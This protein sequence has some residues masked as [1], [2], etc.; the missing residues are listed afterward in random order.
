M[1][2]ASNSNGKECTKNTSRCGMTTMLLLH[3]TIMAFE[4]RDVAKVPLRPPLAVIR[5]IMM[6]KMR[7]TGISVVDLLVNTEETASML[8]MVQDRVTGGAEA[9]IMKI[10]LVKVGVMNP[11]G[12]GGVVKGEVVGS[13]GAAMKVAPIVKV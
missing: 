6:M 9:M 5:A 1:I 10:I 13:A 12:I 3:R 7:T 8:V 11:V 4:G 2:V